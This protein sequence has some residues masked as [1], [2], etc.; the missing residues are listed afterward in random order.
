MVDAPA[1]R[2]SPRDH[3]AGLV[4]PE[5]KSSQP[6]AR[7]IG[8]RESGATV[9]S[10][11]VHTHAISRVAAEKS[12]GAGGRFATERRESSNRRPGSTIGVLGFNSLGRLLAQRASRP[13]AA[14]R[15]RGAFE[16]NNVLRNDN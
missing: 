3:A 13:K 1:L 9:G 5:G 8:A 6:A 4:S 14:A 2:H 11:P 10:R 12:F 16:G 7:E 15:R